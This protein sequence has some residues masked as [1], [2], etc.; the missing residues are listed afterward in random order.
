MNQSQLEQSELEQS[1]VEPKLEQL[2]AR[3]LCETKRKIKSLAY[4]ERRQIG[5]IIDC[6]IDLY[7]GS[8]NRE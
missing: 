3:V 5:A 4:I 8:R 1:Q 6:A 2:H 7:Y